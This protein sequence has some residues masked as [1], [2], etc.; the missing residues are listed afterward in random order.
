M[1][2]KLHEELLANKDV[3]TTEHA[4]IMPVEE[5]FLEI[6]SLKPILKDLES[7][8]KNKHFT[9]IRKLLQKNMYGYTPETSIVDFF[10]E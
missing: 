6:K 10:Y 4:R 2:E 7:T 9:E 1:G 5:K 8:L 3:R